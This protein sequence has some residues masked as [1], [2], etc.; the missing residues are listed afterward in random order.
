MGP[1]TVCQVLPALDGGGVE[2]GTVEIAHALVQAGHRALV[3]SAGGHQEASLAAAGG[4]HYRLAI[5]R[6]SLATLALVGSLR[7]FLI[8]QRVDIV[9]A[10]S[11]LPAWIARLA[12]RSLPMA[13][14]P[15]WVTTVHGLYSVSR[16]SAVMASGER[17]IAVSNTVRD[18]IRANYPATPE[19]H[20]RVIP[21]GVDPAVY[22]RGY[23]PDAHWLAAWR[24]QFPQLAGQLVLLL[25]G[26]LTRL[27]G[28]EAF[29]ELVHRL[30]KAGRPVHGLIVG[31]E[32][33]RRQ[34][35]A[36]QLAEQ[37]RALGLER[38]IT[39]TGHRDDLRQIMSRSDLVLS[40]SSKPEAFGR[41]VLEALALGRPVVGWDHGGVGEVLGDLYP[42]GRVPLADINGLMQRVTNC[43][44]Q[45]PEGDV[46]ERYTL[47]AMGAATLAVYAQTV[48]LDERCGAGV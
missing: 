41:T 43:L 26:R 32:D 3:V 7:R 35:Y 47:A 37:V 39:F 29:I 5:G 28:H 16:Y 21:R 31:G 46:D 34:A 11:R 6:K 36:R 44:G 42:Q 19:T 10:R 18:Y 2:R 1:L 17:V 40:L 14:R 25:P 13:R 48:D 15:R 45:I 33:P 8:E 23:T 20:I 9:H 27:K 38:A 22:H 24:Q 12:I 4:E 30:R